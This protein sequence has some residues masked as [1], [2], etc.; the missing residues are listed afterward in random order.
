[1]KA[2]R[3]W[4]DC[5]ASERPTALIAVDC[6]W[7]LAQA[8]LHEEVH[9]PSELSLLSLGDEGPWPNTLRADQTERP[10]WWDLQLSLTRV[11]TNPMEPR[12]APLR[13]MQISA[14]A[15]P[16]RQMGRWAMQEVLRRLARPDLPPGHE[17]LVGQIV[18]GNSI[19]PPPG[20]GRRG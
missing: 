4:R 1:V 20:A 2:V 12:F 10:H 3:R 19:A 15:L 5:D 11:P 14:V 13:D 9:V 16:F 8:A 18:P 17:K 7:L 6:A